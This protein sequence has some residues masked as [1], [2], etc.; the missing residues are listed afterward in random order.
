[1]MKANLLSAE[2][3]DL[4]EYIEIESAR[5]LHVVAGPSFREGREKFVRGSSGAS[6]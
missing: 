3:L 4:E 6:S 5:H 1:M 2:R